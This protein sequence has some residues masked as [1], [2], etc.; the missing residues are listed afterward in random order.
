M[1]APALHA[2]EQERS[3]EIQKQEPQLAAS[4]K[5]I[6]GKKSKLGLAPKPRF[7]YLPQ[8]GRKI[9]LRTQ[10]VITAGF[11]RGRKLKPGALSLYMGNGQRAAVEAIGSYDLCFPS[12]LVIV[13]HNCHYA[14]SKTRGVRYPKET[15][16]YSFYYPPENKVFVARNAKFENGLLTQEASGNEYDLGGLNEPANYKA[17]LLDLESDKWLNAMNVEMQ[18][19]KDN[20][21]RAIRIL[22]A[23]VAFYDY[24]IWQMDVKTAFLNGYLIREFLRRIYMENSNVRHIPMQEKLKLSKLQGASTPTEV[25]R[26]QIVPYALAVGSIMY[27]MR[28]TR[29]D[30]A[31]AQKWELLECDSWIR[32]LYD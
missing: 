1:I 20:E 24:E 32:S 8:E 4:V 3:K 30:V 9:L 15:M 17:A 7:L 21:I 5:S 31:F 6:R 2:I 22:I 26:M 16:S 29:P 18:S 11:R 27:A 25:K 23:I 14:H 10:S 28:C 12:G 13:L 19:M